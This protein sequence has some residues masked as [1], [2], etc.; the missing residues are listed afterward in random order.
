MEDRVTVVAP[1]RE[2]AGRVGPFRARLDALE[3]VRD[4]LRVVCVEGDSRDETRAL[5][6]EWAAEDSRVCVLACDAVRVGGERGAF[7]AAGACVQ[8]GVGGCGPAMV[9]VC[10]DV[11]ERYCVW[12]GAAGEFVGA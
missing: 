5:L 6:C 9:G 7:C 2:C 3:H 8:Y 11:A 4:R 1:F 12:A 10:D